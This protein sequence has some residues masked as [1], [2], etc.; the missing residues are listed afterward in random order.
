VVARIGQAKNG[1]MGGFPATAQVL[2]AYNEAKTATPKAIADANA[3]FAKAATVSATLSTHKL[4]LAPPKP[5]VPS[6]APTPRR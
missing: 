2:E 6:A 3:L 4:T 1:L 5:V